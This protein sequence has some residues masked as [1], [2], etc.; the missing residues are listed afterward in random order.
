MKWYNKEKTKM[1]DLD[2]IGHWFLEKNDFEQRTKLTINS[3]GIE[4]YFFND[5]AEKLYEVLTTQEKQIL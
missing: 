1:I 4:I 3:C 5:E 2:K